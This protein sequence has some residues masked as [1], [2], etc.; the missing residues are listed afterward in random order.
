MGKFVFPYSEFE[1]SLIASEYIND[2][3]FCLTFLLL[4]SHWRVACTCRKDWQEPCIV[5]CPHWSLRMGPVVHLLRRWCGDPKSLLILE[6][7]CIPQNNA[8]SESFYS[9]IDFI[10][11]KKSIFQILVMQDSSFRWSWNCINQWVYFM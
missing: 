11:F 4:F 2:R 9:F 7:S 10:S 3:W 5:F 8:S 6:V 1:Y